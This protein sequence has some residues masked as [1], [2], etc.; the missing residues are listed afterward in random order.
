[1]L[2]HKGVAF[3]DGRT[4]NIERAYCIGVGGQSTCEWWGGERQYTTFTAFVRSYDGAVRV[5][6]NFK[7][8][9]KGGFRFYDSRL[10]ARFAS[11]SQ[12]AATYGPAA[13]QTAASEQ[14]KGCHQP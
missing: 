12:F 8:T 13:A 9:G 14:A 4:F 10:L 1:M 11:P 2:V 5:L 6:M 7:T 3:N